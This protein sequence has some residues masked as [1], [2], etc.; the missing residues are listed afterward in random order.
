M[1]IKSVKHTT[2]NLSLSASAILAL[3]LAG[4]GGSD[5]STDIKAVDTSA[6][7]SDWVMVWNDEFEGTSIDSAKWT[8][9]VDCAGGG[10][11]EK[12]CYTDS[13]ENSFV[14]DGMLN[15]VAKAAVDAQLPY[16]SARMVT[17]NKGDWKYGR[18]EMRA[19][20]PAGQGSWPAFWMLPT[21]EVYGG[22]PKSGEI[23]I[24]ES[25][26]L[27]TL[28]DAGVEETNI[29]G[30]LHYGR[31][32]PNNES[33]GQAYTPASNPAD[34]FH[35]YAIEWQEGEI[36]WYMDG[37]LYATQMA[38]EV[39]FN[40]KGEAVGL[41]H[42]GWFAEY[43]DIAT[44]EQ[45]TFWDASPFD[46]DFHIILNVAVGGNWPENV[47][48]LGID[49]TAFAGEGQSM[50]VDYVRVYECAAD[51]LT[52]AGCETIRPGYKDEET[53]VE[54]KAPAPTPP[55]PDVAVPITIFS[56]A[57]NPLWKLWDCCGGTTPAVVTDDAQH[58]AVAEFQILD[59]NGTV[60]GFNSRP[61]VSEGGV[62]FN[63]SAML[64]TGN[65]T[66]EM[67]VV[68]D[69]T[70]PTTWLLKVEGDNNTSFAEVALN[71]S[72]EGAAPA[73]GEWQTYT[74]P[75]QTLSDA[76]LDVSAIDVIMIFPAWQTGEGAIYRVDNLTI[77]EPGAQ[78]FPELV[79]FEDQTNLDWPLWD[80]CGGTTPTEEMDDAEHGVVAEFSILDNN[81]TVLGFNSRLP[82]EVAPFDASALLTVGVLEFEMKVVSP[83]TADTTW[84]LKVEADNN[85]SFAEVALNTSTQGL[86]PVTGEWQTYTF[87][88]SDLADAGLDI[89]A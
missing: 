67:K 84:L 68:A 36:R 26:N 65:L 8:H 28:N 71:T 21:D 24:F 18:F 87:S 41:K 29:Y 74:F 88:L 4:C 60:L 50:V 6:P 82:G 20:M 58:G 42:R 17:K 11:Q 51:P 86:D 9:E 27:K 75:L 57:E 78:T 5:T 39:R 80:C 47:N 54:G 3:T 38:S 44:G 7:V 32:F 77:A 25:V 79:I 49:E 72:L 22:W 46:Q 85:T 61:D 55:T 52:G 59:N 30:T 81:G 45:Q 63:A 83:P 19:K 43:F 48:N 14:A 13:A 15:I 33:S 12:Q 64:T 89:S 66:F 31:D 53:L 70:T 10:N 37:Y 62:P 69:T 40:S 76:G 73:V 2:R 23:D 34:G 56:D 35:T 16:S 1:R